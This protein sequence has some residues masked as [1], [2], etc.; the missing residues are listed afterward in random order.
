MSA[1]PDPPQ[2]SVRHQ[3]RDAAI[4]IA[5]RVDPEQP[6]VRRAQRGERANRRVILPAHVNRVV[7]FGKASKKWFELGRRRR[8]VVADADV[9]SAQLAGLDALLMRSIRIPHDAKIVGK[10]I[11]EFVVNPLE[12]R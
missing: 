11:V 8:N 1:D 12:E 2:P 9:E 4:A 6:V 10:A 5:K 7:C 3:A